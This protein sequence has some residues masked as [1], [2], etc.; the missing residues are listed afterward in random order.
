M[1]TALS[2][3]R[4]F[5]LPG[6]LVGDDGRPRRTAELRPLT[7][8]EEEWLAENPD[9]PSARAVT[10]LLS[11]CL[12]RLDDLNPGPDLARRLLVGDR[13]FLMVQ[14]RRITL[15]QTVQAVAPCPACGERMDIEF[16]AS[17]VPV[18]E[19]PQLAETYP[20]ELGRRSL[21]FRLPNGA[22]QEAAL[23]FDE[24][25]AVTV[26][27]DRCLV[28]ATAADLSAEERE[29]VA[30]AM[31]RAAP[32]LDLELAL[33]C[34]ECG[35]NFLLEF[36]MTAFVIDEMRVSARQ[37]L[38]EVHLLA[39]YYHWSEAEV[40]GLRRDRRRSYLSLLRDATRAEWS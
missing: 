25:D 40:L 12:V 31:G 37:L 38:R 30:D 19:R 27:L 4:G 22:D 2:S 11:A 9:A 26:I 13:D 32:R 24:G 39:F 6:G 23:G 29:V 18:T 21:R 15:G 34:P 5:V 1:T 35:H 8:R 33:V 17:A 3:D 14:L 16:D 20:V 10:Q 28:G 36:D 7:G